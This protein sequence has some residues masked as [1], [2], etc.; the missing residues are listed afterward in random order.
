[1][2]ALP[3]ILQTFGGAGAILIVA[4]YALRRMHDQ[5][6][7]TQEKRVAD[8][9][10]F[11]AKLLETIDAQH[12]RDEMIAKALDG[13]A[14]A[15]QEVR[16]YLQAQRDAQRDADR[17]PVMPAVNVNPGRRTRG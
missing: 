16:I 17:Y 3:A 10:A 12:R 14:D 9:Q 5:L 8:A 1:V 15:I 4:G 11:A 2:D 7:A 6:T 13:N